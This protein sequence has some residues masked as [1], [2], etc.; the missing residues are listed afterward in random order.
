MKGFFTKNLRLKLISLILAV[1]LEFYFI[2][3]HNLVTKQLTAPI[4]VVDVPPSLIIISPPS[5]AA[6]LRAEYHVRG[7]IPLV[8]Q[9]EQQT[10]RFVISLA[11]ANTAVYTARLDPREL[12]LPSGVTVVDLEPREIQFQFERL[13]RK[14]L[15][16]TF[17]SPVNAA[18]GYQVSAVVLRPETVIAR[19]PES[20]LRGVKSIATQSIE[21]LENL[22]S[23]ETVEVPLRSPGKHTTLS[24]NSAT[25]ELQISPKLAERVF[26]DVKIMVLTRT[27]A[28]AAA[29]PSQ[30]RLIISGYEDVIARLKESELEVVADVK[31]LTAGQH[32][33]EPKL[34]LPRGTA[35][36]RMEPPAVTVTVTMSRKGGGKDG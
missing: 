17:N 14:E 32:Q 29:S 5:G 3:P 33:V 21:T 18:A 31:S 30:V 28:A 24:V 13:L 35:L 8:Q 19:G 1:S 2:S 36:L 4:E 22:K 20:E 34:V 10:K 27:G 9:L 12:M 15:P 11:D 25:V 23:S 26:N 7:P 16:I 6:D